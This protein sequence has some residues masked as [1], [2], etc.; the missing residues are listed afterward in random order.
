MTDYLALA[1]EFG[2][3]TKLDEVYLTHVLDQLT[4]SQKL[5]FITPPPSVINATF[6]ELY[7]KKGPEAATDYFFQLSTAL[8]LMTASPSFREEKPFIRLNL[9]G[10]SYGFAYVD[11]N[12]K[13]QVF[14]ELASPID[15][16]LLFDIA[17]LFPHYQVWTEEG[18]IFLQNRVPDSVWEEVAQSDFLLTTISQSGNWTKVSGLNQDEVLEA[19][20]AYPGQ[21]YYAWSGREAILYINH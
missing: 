19:A 10:K 12:E 14:P 11:A 4:D 9:T 7:H 18:A 2:G 17:Q 13:A 16:H 6:A 3:F 1:R 21:A 5:M 8:D 15:R 20:Q